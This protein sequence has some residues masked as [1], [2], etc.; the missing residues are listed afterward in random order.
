MKTDVISKYVEK[1][2]AYALKRTFNYY[3][4]EELSQEIL[5][6]AVKELPRL[7]NEDS[8]EPWLWGIA[9]NV[10]R[11]FRR[12]MGKQR[13]MFTYDLPDDIADDTEESE[14]ADEIYSE[15]RANIAMLASTYRDIII[16]Y[17]YDNLS[18][19]NISEKLNIPEGTVTWRLSEARRKLNKECNNMNET[20]LRPRHLDINIH[21]TGNY[22]GKQRP[23]PT[24]YI[25]DALSQNI[26]CYC[27]D[28]A[29]S[30]EDLA[31]LCGT[32]AY[33]IEDRIDNLIKRQAII[34]QSKGKYRTD[35]VIWSDKY[36][37]YLEENAE[38]AL[39]PVMDK[40]IEAIKNIAVGAKEIDFYR[41]GRSENDLF[42]LY[43][44]LAFDYL[45]YNYCT[46]P[47]PPMETKYDGF[48][49]CY[50]GSI[51]TGAHP[52]RSITVQHCGN[53]D[54][55]G[56]FSHTVYTHFAGLSFR[57]MM[58]DNY[59]DACADILY[60]GSTKDTDSASLAIQDG[61]I[62]RREDDTLFITCP[63]FTAE[64]KKAFNALIK[65]YLV[66]LVD[67]Y[68]KCTEKLI[69]GYKK[70]FPKHLQDE[71]DRFCHHMFFSL[72]SVVIDYAQKNGIIKMPSADNYCDVMVEIW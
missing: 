16:L 57:T 13:A 37:K 26:L 41:A 15:L 24:A 61:Y 21:G 64:Q 28:E 66:P 53:C 31:K 42:Y 39:S 14:A 52:R 17:Y 12:R 56:R 5:V 25:D 10:T 70:L 32:P 67:E 45:R 68:T 9:G 47:Y 6:T 40:I 63:S 11:T 35:F 43:G 20:A 46:L 54:I 38:I 30:I 3:E 29:Q 36:G 71:A 27:Y 51:E 69:A 49:W 33:Y 65:K 50:H 7:K 1:V 72:Y 44:A 23:F 58:Y 8:F 34:E 62:V 22:D 55:K 2:F 48:A 18:V 60:T 19:K 4:A 59:I